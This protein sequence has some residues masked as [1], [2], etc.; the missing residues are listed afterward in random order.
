MGSQ[1]SNCWASVV[2][3]RRGYQYVREDIWQAGGWKPRQD[4]TRSSPGDSMIRA[5]RIALR[6]S[7]VQRVM[8]AKA[9]GCARAA[10]NWGLGRKQAAWKLRKAAIEAGVNPTD[11]PKVPSAI[12]LHRDLVLLKKIPVE[13]GGFPWMYESSKCAPQEALR[14]LDVAFTATFRRLKAGENPGFPRFKSKRP[15][16]GHFRVSCS[17]TVTEQTITLPKI[18]AVRIQPGDRGYA[19]AG[20]YTSGAV[21]QEHGEWFVSVLLEITDAPEIARPDDAPRVGLDIGVRKLAVLSDGTIFE[22]PRALKAAERRLKKAQRTLSRRR[23]GSGRRRRARTVFAHRHRRVVRVRKD[24][25]HKATTAITRTCPI[26]VIEDLKVRNM[27]RATSGK[28]RRAKAGLNRSLLDAGFGEFRR[29]LTYKIQR[30]G[31][32][33]MVVHPAYTSQ[34]CSRCQVRTDCGSNEIFTCTACGFTD[35]RDFNAARN[36]RARSFEQVVAASWPETE[37]ARGG[38]VRRPGKARS[39]TPT[40]RERGHRG[41]HG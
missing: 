10:W 34:I 27:T 36:I 4:S 41:V 37:N 24:A 31:G 9:A 2:V 12:D 13:D 26:V 29:Q 33:L 21:V 1:G 8:L 22:N 39:H 5:Y 20:R 11:A 32:R 14:D 23:K 30:A 15:G 18:G 17:V 35:D 38:E 6:P 40:K 28:G 7:R 19:P 25:I 16:E 3:N